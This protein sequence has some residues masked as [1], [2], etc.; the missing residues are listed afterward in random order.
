MS[1]RASAARGGGAAALPGV[2]VAARAR[3]GDGAAGLGQRGGRR[4]GGRGAGA[5]ERGAGAA[6]GP[7]A[8]LHGAVRG[9]CQPHP[10]ADR[11]RAPAP[12]GHHARQ[13]G[14]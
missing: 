5:A 13:N 10:A 6:G 4:P 8:A 12:D 3:A 1:H 14:Q 11:R 2:R 9:Q 7:A